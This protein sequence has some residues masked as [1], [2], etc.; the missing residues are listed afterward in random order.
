MDKIAVERTYQYLLRSAPKKPQIWHT[1]S[2]GLYK[3]ASKTEFFATLCLLKIY[4]SLEET[5][6]TN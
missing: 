3:K 1:N 5:L 2:Q 4:V 6:I